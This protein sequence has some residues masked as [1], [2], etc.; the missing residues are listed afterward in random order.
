MHIIKHSIKE[1][2]KHLF[3]YLLFVTACVI[4]ILTVSI[5]RGERLMEYLAVATFVLFYIC[6]G[7]YHHIVDNTLRFRIVFEYILFGAIGL[8]LLKIIII[9]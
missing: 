1:F 3:D 5:F 6:W 4:F 7:I 8:F 2:Q 9:P